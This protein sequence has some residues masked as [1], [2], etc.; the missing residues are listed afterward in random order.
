M[1]QARR[2]PIASAFDVAFERWTVKEV[3]IVIGT[4]AIVLN[5]LAATVRRVALVA[6]RA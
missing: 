5:S 3:H 1:R 2:S 4:L 6:R